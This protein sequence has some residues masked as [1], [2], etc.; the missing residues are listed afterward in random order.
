MSKAKT[1]RIDLSEDRLLAIAADYTD[2]HNYIGALRMLNKNAEINFNAEDSYMLYAEVF[3]DMGLPEKSVNGWFKYIDYL[4]ASSDADLSEAYEGLAVNYLNLGEE[5]IAAFW[6]N[7]LLAETDAELTPENRQEI[8]NSFI[9]R[10]KSPLKIAWPPK[11][12]DFS[13]EMERGIGYMRSG[14]YEKAVSEFDKV[15]EGNKS[16]LT[17]RNYIAMCNIICDRTDEA[18]QEC[19]NV[20]K[21]YPDD[22][23]ALTTLAAVKNQQKQQGESVNLANR[24]LSVGA[25]A[26][27]DL[28]KIATVCCENGMHEQAY[29]LFCKIEQDL[30][31]DKTVLYFKAVSAYNAGYK[32]ES[33]EAFE[34]LLTIYPDAV[35][36][37][38]YSDFVRSHLGEG[39]GDYKDNPITY[40]YRLPQEERE[41]NLE[42]LTAFVRLKPR[43]AEAI[44]RELDITDCI[45]WCFDEGGEHGSLELKLLA[46]ACAV[47]AE[48]CDDILRDI[49]LD[50]FQ[51]DALKMQTLGFI[52][53][54][55]ED[56]NYGVVV[57]HVY[58]EIAVPALK[59]P[60]NK[61]KAFV[62]AYAMTVARFALIDPDYVYALNSA[63]VKLYEKLSRAGN[64]NAAKDVSAL[65]AAIFS[66]SGIS[67]DG[68]A[69]EA[70]SYFG[71]NIDNYNILMGE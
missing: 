13:G 67:E 55:N 49:L 14:D 23:Q 36:A 29:G 46:A 53:E 15:E 22:V 45:L 60:R 44:S 9:V 27:E 65:A 30:S 47:M 56:C 37:R 25:T 35:T 31:Y 51:P 58:R 71:A 7:K 33:L 8:I 4:R 43:H 19:L 62:K 11:L 17:A 12:A 69:E 26:T 24:L 38:Y 66:T 34:K 40:F 61:K 20:L 59:L 2:N 68:T 63:A 50:A 64:L 16:Y 39:D 10:R 3:D 48:G 18:E 6:Y 57:C 70:C 42:I 28:Y 54:R 41:S 1:L 21:K 52:A 5:E 32:A